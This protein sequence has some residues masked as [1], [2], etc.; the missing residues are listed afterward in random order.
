MRPF[1]TRIR[2]LTIFEIGILSLSVA[3][4]LQT[5][6]GESAQNTICSTSFFNTVK[7]FS[8][9]IT[10]GTLANLDLLSKGP[11]SHLFLTKI[12]SPTN[13]QNGRYLML[14]IN[15]LTCPLSL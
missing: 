14:N 11:C 10:A 3:R 5:S 9:P 6:L 8:G 15:N 13:K 12:R 7:G 2:T 1:E 4:S